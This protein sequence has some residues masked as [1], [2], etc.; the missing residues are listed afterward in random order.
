MQN[1]MD[2]FQTLTAASSSSSPSLDDSSLQRSLQL[3]DHKSNGNS[4][5]DIVV[6]FS[7]GH[8]NLHHGGSRTTTTIGGTKPQ[9]HVTK[10]SDMRAA[11]CW[12][13]IILGLVRF[14]VQLSFFVFNIQPLP[15]SL[16]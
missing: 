12:K 11:R 13:Y 1:K 7:A 8:T 6:D 14:E 15:F 10:L 3:L 2:Q 5:H 4:M 9:T 16:L